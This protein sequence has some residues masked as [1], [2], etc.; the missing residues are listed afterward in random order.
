MYFQSSVYISFST[1]AGKISEI[2]LRIFVE[3]SFLEAWYQILSCR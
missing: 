2:F 1:T 3:K